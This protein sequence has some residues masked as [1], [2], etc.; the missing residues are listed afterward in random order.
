MYLSRQRNRGDKSRNHGAP[1]SR[2][3]EQSR[4]HPDRQ[5]KGQRYADVGLDYMAIRQ[6]TRI[7]QQ[8]S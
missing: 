2:C 3:F 5:R 7:E 8:H 6:H 4:E 1:H